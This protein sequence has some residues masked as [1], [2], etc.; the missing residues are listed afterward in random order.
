MTMD[1]SVPMLNAE[2]VCGTF[3]FHRYLIHNMEQIEIEMRDDERA[4]ADRL[5]EATYIVYISE[6][7][8]YLRVHFKEEIVY[9]QAVR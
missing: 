8:Q 5:M 6:D 1:R 4:L 2:N 9:Y 7:R 3:A